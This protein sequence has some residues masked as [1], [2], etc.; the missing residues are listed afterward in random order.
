M[1]EPE[2]C[3]SGPQPARLMYQ[4]TCCKNAGRRGNHADG[5][6]RQCGPAECLLKR[7]RFC[8]LSDECRVWQ[9]FDLLRCQLRGFAQELPHQQ[10]FRADSTLAR[11]IEEFGIAR[12]AGSAAA[13]SC[14]FSQCGSFIHPPCGSRSRFLLKHVARLP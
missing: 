14:S 9:I 11:V 1:L 12:A 4:Q 8:P 13:T 2:V 6:Y 10:N 5:P 3:Q 7:R